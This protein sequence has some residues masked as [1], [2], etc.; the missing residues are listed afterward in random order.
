MF[1]SSQHLP[2]IVSIGDLEGR[3]FTRCSTQ[4]RAGSHG[5]RKIGRFGPGIYGHLYELA[6]RNPRETV[7]LQNRFTKDKMCKKNLASDVFRMVSVTDFKNE[8][9]GHA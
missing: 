5:N 4:V 3:N 7:E 9:P 1:A 6:V 2:A 8:F